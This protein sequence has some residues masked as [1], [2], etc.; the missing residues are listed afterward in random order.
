MINTLPNNKTLEAQT[1]GQ[2]LL[3]KRPVPNVTTTDF[4]NKDYRAIWSAIAELD[5]ESKEI[6]PFSVIQIAQ[7]NGLSTEFKVSDLMN[8][9]LGLVPNVDYQLY[10]EK[11][12]TLS[13][14]RY[15]MRELSNHIEALEAGEDVPDVIQTLE[16]RFDTLRSDYAPKNERFQSLA[17]II[18]SDVKPALMELRQGITN[19]IS[20]G[21]S[22]IDRAIGGGL[23]KS[24][25]VV[26]AADTGGG[27]SA[28][29]LQLAANMAANQIPVAFLSGEMTPRENGLR[30]ISQASQTYNLNSTTKIYEDEYNLLMQWAEAS[31]R[32]PLYV[33][34]KTTD[35]KTL[36]T[37]LKSLVKTK[38]IQVLV[39]DYLQLLKNDVNDSRKRHERISDASQE[40]KRIALELEI[41]V[42][43]V[44]QYNREGGKSAKATF[45]DLEGSGQIEK[46]ASLIFLIDREK[47]SDRVV[48]RIEKGRN[49]GTCPIEGT[50][51]GA[52][53][54]F[55][56]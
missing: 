8:T 22:S 52:N 31:K 55:K 5:K 10:A 32:L 50:F 23:S 7:R 1:I 4:Y 19:K 46:D 40:I 25:V 43:E 42:I 56:F 45:H 44:V 39:I 9:T 3:E 54:N 49:A 38:G 28:F 51:T 6:E 34:S 12:K 30:L 17:E 35:L 15:L 21:F 14:R 20:T 24:D 11:L 48:L 26:V 13:L 47:D 37:S 29:V 41:A 18:E 36:R 53:L 33:D 2:T 27:K 16:T